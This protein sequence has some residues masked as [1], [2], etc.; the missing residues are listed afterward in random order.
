M[1][2]DFRKNQRYPKPVYIE[3]EAVERV[4]TYKYLGVVFDSKLNWKENI[5]SVLKKVN[6]RMCCMRKLRSFG[7]NSDMLVTFYNAVICSIIMFDSVCWGG[8][9]SKLDRGRLEKIV[10]KAGHVVGK[11]LDSFKTLHEKRLYRKLMHL[12]NDPTHPVRQYFDS[13]RSNR[14]YKASFLPSALSVFNENYT[15]H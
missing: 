10:K 3:G 8:N 14:S 4:V 13:R 6:S 9:I 2:I 12:L 15:S 7:V 5:N 1:C 11:P